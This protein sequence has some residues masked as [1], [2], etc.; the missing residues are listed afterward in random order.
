VVGSCECSNKPLTS[1]KYGNFSDWLKICLLLERNYAPWS[2]LVT[3][4]KIFAIQTV[5]YN[6]VLHV[7]CAYY[8]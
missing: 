6:S 1:I 8:E 4:F 7:H 2:E 3:I 5:S